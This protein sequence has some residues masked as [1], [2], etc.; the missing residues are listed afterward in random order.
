MPTRKVRE[1][2]TSSIADNSNSKTCCK[3][4]QPDG[5]ACR[6][7]H[8][9]RVQ[10]HL[11]DEVVGDDHRGDESVDGQDLGHDGTEAGVEH[12]AVS[13]RSRNRRLIAPR[14]Y[15]FCIIL[16]GLMSPDEKMAPADLAVP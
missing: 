4:A 3:A 13:C 14:T 10:G 15:V 11:L 6:E 2:L 7:L 16:S 9:S 8:E 1:K 12:R 5:Q